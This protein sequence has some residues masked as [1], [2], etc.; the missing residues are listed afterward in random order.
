MEMGV[1]MAINRARMKS[2]ADYDIAIIGG[3]IAGLCLSIQLANAGYHVVLFEKEQYPFHKVCGEYL[4]MESWDFLAHLGV[5]LND[6]QQPRIKHLIVSSPSGKSIHHPLEPGGF[7]ISRYKLDAFLASLARKAGV[8]LMEGTKVENL[9]FS[10][11]QFQVQFNGK[12]CTATLASGTFGKRSN[13]DVK[14][15]REFTLNKPNKT[16]HYIAVKYH[17]K[18]DFPTDHIALHNFEN[19]YC[20]VSRIEDER[21]CLCYMTTAKNLQ[22]CGNDI[23]QLEQHI[24]RRNPFLNRLFQSS[25]PLYTSP[26]TISQISFRS[27]TQ[28]EQHILMA[29]D[30][31]GMI[32]PLSG[33]G[34]SMA[35]LGSKIAFQLMHRFLQG[36]ISRAA[37]EAAYQTQWN[38]AF[39]KRIS[40][41][42]WIQQWF[43]KGWMTDAFIGAIKPFPFLIS[44]LIN[45]THGK[46]F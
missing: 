32:P 44:K 29:G 4:S 33:N 25:E 37:L 45:Q 9:E 34:M 14:L 3:G 1:S 30:A 40:T 10:N 13:L 42:R 8:T 35:M 17:V 24:L 16:N 19:G 12:Q 6:W 21:Y 38:A 18:T 7:G 36:E 27:K 5:P 41:G 2:G 43:G 11:D 20:G 46:P 15:K 23:S 26:L 28:T 39:K 31:A 22:T